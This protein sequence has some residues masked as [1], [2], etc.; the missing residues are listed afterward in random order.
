[1][2]NLWVCIAVCL[3][4]CASLPISDNA[5]KPLQTSALQS[6]LTAQSLAVG[7]CGVFFWTLEQPPVFTFFQKEG[8]DH[9]KYFHNGTEML[10]T[11]N[12]KLQS[13]Q[14]GA[15]LNI[16]Y[17]TPQGQTLQI[18]GRFADIL[19]GGQRISNASIRSQTADGWQEILPV[20]GVY[21]C[22]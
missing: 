10:L 4:A 16:A 13:F 19:E 12:V 18:K 17:T 15:V 6:S 2:R 5:K 14:N 11:P 3:S 20:S 21:V 8:A 1:M 9:A 22:R 7:E